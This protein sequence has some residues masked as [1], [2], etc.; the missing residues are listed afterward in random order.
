MYKKFRAKKDDVIKVILR[1]NSLLLGGRGWP[2]SE[3][4]DCRASGR[5]GWCQ[6]VR[7]GAMSRAFVKEDAETLE[8]LPDRLISQHP[9]DVTQQGMAHLQAMLDAAREAH[10]AALAAQDRGAMA[11]ASRELRYWSARRATARVIPDSTDTTKVHF[12]SSV[13]IRRADG[14]EQTFRI[15]GEDEADP[16]HGTISHASPLARSLIG[17]SVGDVVKLGNREVEIR[18]IR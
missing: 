11:Q 4:A 7:A 12:G 13:S 15:V 17:K 14:R 2:V 8:E 5:R 6:D 1:L 10:A 9:N 16:A 3:P 18:A